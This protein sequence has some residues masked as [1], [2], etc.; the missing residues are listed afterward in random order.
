MDKKITIQETRNYSIFKRLKGNR[1]IT[2]KRIAIIKASIQSVGYISNPII[3][4]E[5]MEVI[6]GQGRL[7]VMEEL[8]LPVEYRVIKGIGITECRAMNLKPTAWSVDDFVKSYAEY[9]NENYIRLIELSK[10]YGFG[11]QLIGTIIFDSILAGGHA[12][13]ELRDGTFELTDADYQKA[14]DMCEY[15]SLFKDVQPKIGGR[16][17]CFYGCIAWIAKLPRINKNRLNTAIHK[18][19][20]DISPMAKA[21]PALRQISDVYNNGYARNNRRDFV[22]EWKF[23]NTKK[24]VDF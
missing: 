2:N 1:D 7:K 19:Y 18:R 10:K 20:S 4:N 17:D 16:K 5:N 14:K 11:Y 13:Y 3:V 6:D 15:L 8:R 24:E 23:Q 21:E 12:T 9:G 22:Y